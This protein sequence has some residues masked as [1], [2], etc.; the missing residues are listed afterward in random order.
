MRRTTLTALTLAAAALLARAG[1][2]AAANDAKARQE[3]LVA[4]L[5]SEAGLHE[6]AEA[7]RELG[8]YGTQD[9]VPA[10]A[11]LLTDEKL[12]T[13]ARTALQ[14]IP[15]PAVDD[16][17]RAAL[18]QAKGKPLLGVLNS[19]GARRDVKAVEQVA[20]LL[21]DPDA[22]TAAAAAGTLGRIGNAAAASALE[23]ALPNAAPAVLPAVCEG[24]LFCAEAALAQ[25]RRD[26]AAALY[27][28]VRGAQAPRHLRMA[29]MRGAIV[30][31]GPAGIPLLSE[32]LKS[33]DAGMFAAALRA[34]Q[35]LSGAEVTQALGAELGK[36]SPEKQIPLVQALGNRGDAAAVPAVMALAKSGAGAVRVAAIRVLTQLGDGSALPLLVELATGADAEAARAAQISLASFP[37][38]EADS[39]IASLLNQPDAKTRC[40]ALGLLGQL[41][42]TS[43]MPALLK[44]AED[45]DEQ[46]RL[47]S[48]KVLGEL[49]GPA[50]LPAILGFLAKAKSPQEAQAAE[51]AL[52]AICVRQ[53]EREACAERV[54]GSLTSAQGGQKLALL[55][56]LRSAGGAKALAAVRAATSDASAEVKGEA[57][58]VLCDWPT[59]E[60]LPD[61]AGLAKT[62]T[63]PKL[64]I[65]A[66][67]GYIRLIPKQDAPAE[68]KVAA[69]KEA[70]ALVERNDEKKLVLAALAETP[71]P[72]AAKLIEQCLGDAAVKA[73]A[74]MALL[75]LCQVLAGANPDDVKALLEKLLAA[76][77]NA[78]LKKQI[79]GLRQQLEK[80]ADFVTAWQV[81]GPYVQDG[82]DG[83]ALRDVVFPPEKPDAKN[84]QWAML[85]PAA[86]RGGAML[87]DL[88][89]ACGAGE[90]KAA[91]V[92][93]WI[94]SQKEQP[95][96]F[97][98][99]TDDCHKVWLN[100]KQISTDSKGGAATPEKF[101]VD[102]TLRQN[103][104]ALLLKVTQ[105]SGPWE[106]CF[107]IRK[108][109]GSKLEGLTVQATPPAEP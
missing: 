64:K 79:Q 33:D 3:Q 54:A 94:R 9:A 6:K 46:V 104:N 52:T 14:N 80:S 17:L 7:C 88:A 106:F 84:V 1:E 85:P 98:F 16:A 12:S 8:V 71:H 82:T 107:R 5:K 19:V 4:V 95:A 22:E 101:K 92:R 65:L 86:E 32:Q 67:R 102:V 69:L 23:R 11:A 59:A 76:T 35:E 31:R 83:F 47:A 49:A 50:E 36:L 30:A 29:G 105:V 13:H 24:C 56:V 45:A 27:D 25:G 58:R 42:V 78:D 10:L 51:G 28:R 73:E 20:K 18:S 60:A 63:D 48:L 41:R 66:L 57:Q 81:T 53:A 34:A 100:G 26:E 62:A 43:A 21:A 96:R 90:A 55:R 93:T 89:A 37:A 38:K 70:L 108:P 75:R 87:H 40:M 103:C 99:G 72:E 97:E 39:T 15:D 77:A 68:K 91:Y 74:E 44:A 109:D 2:P 61:L